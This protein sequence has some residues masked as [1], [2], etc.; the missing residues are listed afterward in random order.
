MWMK[1]EKRKITCKF[2]TSNDLEL[3]M[4]LW[5]YGFLHST[6]IHPEDNLYYTSHISLKSLSSQPLHSR[7]YWIHR[8]AAVSL[9]MDFLFRGLVLQFCRFIRYF[10][11][12]IF[13]SNSGLNAKLLLSTI[14]KPQRKNFNRWTRGVCLLLVTLLRQQISCDKRNGNVDIS[15]IE[16]AE[17]IKKISN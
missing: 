10:F 7:S 15:E 2:F 11:Y 13:S 17:S 1:R 16:W 9:S 8:I 12:F 5:L 6:R 3:V 14:E 4:R